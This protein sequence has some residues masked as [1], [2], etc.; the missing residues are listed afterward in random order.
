MTWHDMDRKILNSKIELCTIKVNQYW[1]GIS[2]FSPLVIEYFWCF[3]ISRKWLILL[4]TMPEYVIVHNYL[5]LSSDHHRGEECVLVR[6][7]ARAG[8]GRTLGAPSSESRVLEASGECTGYTLSR[9]K[10]GPLTREK[11]FLRQEARS[12]HIVLTT[13]SPGSW[14]YIHHRQIVASN[15]SKK[16]RLYKYLIKG[17]N[18][19]LSLIN[20]NI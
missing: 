20:V 3:P 11:S 10:P 9:L 19:W 15:W 5:K 18:D 14:P 8:E 13:L 16:N 6:S 12:Q 1:K 2:A 17:I 4:Q 7:E